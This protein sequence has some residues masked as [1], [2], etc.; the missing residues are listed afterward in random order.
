MLVFSLVI[1]LCLHRLNHTTIVLVDL[2]LHR[3]HL[4]R[5]ILVIFLSILVVRLV[6][7]PRL[8]GN[9]IDGSNAMILLP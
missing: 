6:F 3:R 7:A 9:S 8:Y 2:R 1:D 4:R 5:I